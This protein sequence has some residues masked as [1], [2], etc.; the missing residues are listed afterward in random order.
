MY[1]AAADLPA[2]SLFKLVTEAF[3]IQQVGEIGKEREIVIQPVGCRFPVLALIGCRKTITTGITAQIRVYEAAV[4]DQAGLHCAQWDL[5]S[6]IP[7]VV[8]ALKGELE[9]GRYRHPSRS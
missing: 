1:L 6:R 4:A 3:V 9:S 7:G 8:V 5:I 2:V